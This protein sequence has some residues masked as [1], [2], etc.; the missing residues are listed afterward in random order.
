MP[1]LYGRW[2]VGK[3]VA[4]HAPED[5][6]GTWAEY[7]AAEL[8]GVVP[9]IKDVTSEQGACFVVNPLTAWTLLSIAKES[10]Q[11]AFI[12][13][14]AASAIGRMIDRL[15]RRKG[16][17]CVNIVRRREQVELMKKEGAIHV[18]DTSQDGWQEQLKVLSDRH[19]IGMA[20]DAVGGELSGQV[21]QA[22]NKDG[23]LIVYGA[24]AGENCQVS[25]RSLLFEGK[26][27]EGFW[28]T[29]WIKSRNRLQILRMAYQ[30]QKLLRSDLKT[31]VQARF[32]LDKIQD[33]IA[34]YKQKRT[35][36]KVLLIPTL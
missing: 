32:P 16:L 9:L 30:A 29:R 13:T 24:L 15:S 20:F 18:L 22:L 21:A 26:R 12:Q 14:A 23:R 25:P 2:L 3:R 11:Q 33:A 10:G 8:D 31:D 4:C 19:H 1:V 17:V 34:L 5:G 27:L 28:I 36:G 6:N 35:D 7:M